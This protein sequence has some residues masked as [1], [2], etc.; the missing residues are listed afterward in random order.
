MLEIW[1]KLSQSR[2]MNS[3]FFVVK[4]WIFNYDAS[5]DGKEK[6][7]KSLIFPAKSQTVQFSILSIKLDNV[8]NSKSNV[9][10]QLIPENSVDGSFCAGYSCWS[11][12]LTE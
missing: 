5:D 12:G 7:S 11:N 2:E 10:F 6:L 1:I 8:V 4:T 9:E 3:N